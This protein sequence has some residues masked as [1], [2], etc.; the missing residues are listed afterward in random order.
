MTYIHTLT[1]WPQ[2]N[3]DHAAIE[4]SLG[5]AR[6]AQGRLLGRM[7]ALGFELRSEAMLTALTED[8]VKTSEIE[9]ESLNR[10]DVRS[11]LAR[12]IGIETAGVS[13]A[14]RS[15]EG[16]VEVMLD[17]TEN[18]TA[19]LTKERLFGWH[20][21]LF[22]TG[23]SGMRPITVGAWRTDERGPM[24]VV[25]GP[26]GKETV[27]FEAP[28]ASRLPEEMRRFLDWFNSEPDVE[29]V[30]FAA[31]AHFWFVTLHPFDDGNGRIARAIGDMALARS[32]GTGK[33]FYAMASAIQKER[34]AYYDIL[35]QTQHGDLDITAWLVWFLGT[36]KVAL[37]QA[38]DLLSAVRHK[39]AVWDWLKDQ[40][41]N[42]RQRKVINRLLDGF[43]G[44]LNTSKWA[45]LAK[46]SKDTALRDI[47]DL[48]ERGVLKRGDGGGRSTH[49]VLVDP[50]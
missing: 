42:D 49:Y 5:E 3:W 35:E 9:G 38:D 41:L 2:F 15:V 40:P 33:R 47:T 12:R 4:K 27:H 43:E 45:A 11:S 30:V 21:A 29:P 16:I 13:P 22:P 37:A 25:S 26:I 7:E 14:D 19:P 50:A 31:L 36:L 32:E 34:R 1:S 8:V 39:A 48:V 28:A 24:Q 18:Y 6:H 10:A 23:R 44:K 46:T 17:A 20:A